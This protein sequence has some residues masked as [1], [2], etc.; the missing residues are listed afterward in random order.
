MGELFE[1]IQFLIA[2]AADAQIGALISAAASIL[3]LIGFGWLYLGP[4]AAE[5]RKRAAENA[6]A[7]QRLVSRQEVHTHRL[8]DLAN[9]IARLDN[10][11]QAIIDRMDGR[12]DTIFDR[13]DR[14]QG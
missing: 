12:I 13:L 8:E 3:T 2:K 4:Q 14:A 5:T 7:V 9:D 6:E 11:L 1:L 10:R